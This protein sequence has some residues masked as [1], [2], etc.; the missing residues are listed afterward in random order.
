[1]PIDISTTQIKRYLENFKPHLKEDIANILCDGEAFVNAFDTRSVEIVLEV[2]S[3]HVH[4]SLN[5]MLSMIRDGKFNDEE[6][7]RRIRQYCIEI[8]TINTLIVHWNGQL[9]TLNRHLGNMD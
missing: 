2:I 6:E 3:G 4:N 1:M 8:N 5:S 7:L 9:E